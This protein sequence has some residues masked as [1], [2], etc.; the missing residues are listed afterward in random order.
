MGMWDKKEFY[1]KICGKN[2]YN[3]VIESQIKKVS[4]KREVFK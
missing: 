3:P 1:G 4:M 2:V